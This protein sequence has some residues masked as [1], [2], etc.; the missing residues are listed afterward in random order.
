[1]KNKTNLIGYTIIFLSYVYFV[2]T[3]DFDNPK[4]KDI[5]FSIIIVFVTIL[6]KLDNI[7]DDIK[8]FKK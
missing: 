8:N 2:F 4:P 5:L 1:M 3:T 6:F 7:H